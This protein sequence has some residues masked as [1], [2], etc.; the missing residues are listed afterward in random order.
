MLETLY[1]G[2]YVEIK[3]LVGGSTSGSTS[4]ISPKNLHIYGKEIYS[5]AIPSITTNPNTSPDIVASNVYLHGIKGC[6]INISGSSSYSDTTMKYIYIE[7]CGE[8]S[9][10]IMLHGGAGN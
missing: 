9:D 2:D 3:Q 10:H 1:L 4:L 6:R 8:R 5:T 7:C